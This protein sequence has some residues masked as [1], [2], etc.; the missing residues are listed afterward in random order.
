MIRTED[1]IAASFDWRERLFRR[2]ESEKQDIGEIKRV[3]GGL[4]MKAGSNRAQTVRDPT[5][6]AGRQDGGES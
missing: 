1:T 4:E 6:A 3:G 5:I 2:Y